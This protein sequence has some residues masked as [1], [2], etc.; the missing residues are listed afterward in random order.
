[1]ALVIVV[2]DGMRNPDGTLR[3]MSDENWFS[4]R[5]FRPAGIRG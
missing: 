2:D 5:D 3:L 1:M 4:Q